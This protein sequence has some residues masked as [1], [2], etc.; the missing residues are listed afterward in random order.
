MKDLSRIDFNYNW[1][2]KLAGKYFTTIQLK[3]IAKYQAGKS[4]NIFLKGKFLCRACIVDIKDFRL[5]DLNAYM[6][7]IDTGYSLQECQDL[8]RTMYKN[9]VR[10]WDIQMLSMILL[11][12]ESSHAIQS[13]HILE[14][15][16]A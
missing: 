3:N 8:I 14:E 1:N 16:H 12:K 13:Q 15:A 2:N 7:G 11:C 4:Y 9:F 6:A 10:D 5:K